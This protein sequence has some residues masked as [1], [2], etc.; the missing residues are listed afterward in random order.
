VARFDTGQ[1]QFVPVP[2]D[3]GDASDQVFLLLFGTGTR[4]RSSL[5]SVS[6]TI[7]G[8]AAEVLY[9][10]PQGG[11]VGL[12]QLNVRLPRALS[13]RGEVELALSVEGVAANAVRVSFK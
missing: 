7:G 12:D 5:A 1:N 9:A 11:F 6:V 13:G 3:V 2:L 10:G 8:V 4:G